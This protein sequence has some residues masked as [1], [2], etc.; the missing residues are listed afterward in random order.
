MSLYR[1]HCGCSVVM[2]EVNSQPMFEFK[3]IQAFGRVWSVAEWV[4]LLVMIS[5][6][7]AFWLGAFLGFSFACFGSL[8]PLIFAILGIGYFQARW[9]G[10]IYLRESII[11]DKEEPEIGSNFPSKG[12]MKDW[13]KTNSEY[14]MAWNKRQYKAS[15]TWLGQKRED[16]VEWRHQRKLTK[17]RA[18]PQSDSGVEVAVSE[19]MGGSADPLAEGAMAKMVDNE[20]ESESPE[21]EVEEQTLLVIPEPPIFTTNRVEFNPRKPVLDFDWAPSFFRAATKVYFAINAFLFALALF[22]YAY[23]LD[24]FSWTIGSY[25]L[26]FVADRLLGEYSGTL[27]S[28][29]IRATIL[30]F[31]LLC[32]SLLMLIGYRPSVTIVLLGFTF[33]LSILMRMDLSDPVSNGKTIVIDFFWCFYMLVYASVIFF[34]RDPDYDP[35]IGDIPQELI[36]ESD[37]GPLGDNMDMTM[38]IKPKRP[39]RRARP[40]LFYEGFFLLIATLLWPLSLFCLAALASADL[41]ADYGLPGD[42]SSGA[43]SGQIFL[44]LMFFLATASTFIV[45][46][47]DREARDDPMYAKEKAHYVEA[48]EHWININKDYYER[49]HARLTADLPKNNSS[50]E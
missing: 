1:L 28:T 39:H 35:V 23:D 38:P 26:E 2:D 43:L 8:I 11:V 7:D 13:V 24:L 31:L 37:N 36:S 16:W 42:F 17:Y 15:T 18:V 22:D 30:G 48:M 33:I 44:C 3:P 25:V 47:Y 10:P 14:F 20:P 4:T 34:A 6:V 21:R 41:R 40:L 46:K 29:K 12:E 45:Y 19:V 50:E 9:D 5:F 27:I 49:A 32:V